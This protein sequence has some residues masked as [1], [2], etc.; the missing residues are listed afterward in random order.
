MHLLLH[1]FLLI[2]MAQLKKQSFQD[3]FECFELLH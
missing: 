3:K 2:I 1:T